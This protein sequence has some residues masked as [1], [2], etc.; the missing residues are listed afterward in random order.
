MRSLL[1]CKASHFV[2][3]FVDFDTSESTFCQHFV[4]IV[5]KF[6]SK[7]DI[8]SHNE[9][10]SHAV[11]ASF[12]DGE[13]SDLFGIVILEFKRNVSFGSIRTDQ[14]DCQKL[15]LCWLVFFESFFF[16]VSKQ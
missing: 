9:M 1:R 8:V 6:E 2:F 12:F 3:I 14:L 10:N 16:D 13:L 4:Y 5:D 15:N 11:D 7:N